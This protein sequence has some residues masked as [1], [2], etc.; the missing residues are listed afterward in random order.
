MKNF[1]FMLTTT[2]NI[3]YVIPGLMMKLKKIYFNMAFIKSLRIKTKG[4][5]SSPVS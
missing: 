4:S 3:Y 5:G 1:S 2:A